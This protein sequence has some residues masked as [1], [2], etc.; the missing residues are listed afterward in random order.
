[1][2]MIMVGLEVLAVVIMI[3][4]TIMMTVMMVMIIMIMIMMMVVVVLI[5]RGKQSF[6]EAM[7]LQLDYLFPLLISDEMYWF[8]ILT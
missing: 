4:T 7:F 5:I 1:M 3:V 6:C 8:S 2:V